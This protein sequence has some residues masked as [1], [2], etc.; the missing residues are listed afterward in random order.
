MLD[1]KIGERVHA[2]CSKNKTD[3]GLGT[4]TEIPHTGTPGTRIMIKLDNGDHVTGFEC[5]WHKITSCVHPVC[6]WYNR[7][8]AMQAKDA[9]NN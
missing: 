3:F 6:T 8:K 5:W 1:I 9:N 4:I 7:I 2:F